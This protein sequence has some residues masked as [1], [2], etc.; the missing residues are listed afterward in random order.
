MAEKAE[1]QQ[2]DLK[3]FIEKINKKQKGHNGKRVHFGFVTQKR[4]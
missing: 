2:V 1:K 3:T 4:K